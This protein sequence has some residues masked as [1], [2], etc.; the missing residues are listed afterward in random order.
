VRPPTD[1]TAL[2]VLVVAHYASERLGGEGAIPLQYYRRLRA[3]GVDVRLLTHESS[4]DE[5]LDLLPDDRERLTFAPSLPGFGPVFTRGE[6][7]PGGFRNLAW[8]VTQL[9]RQIPLRRAARELVAVHGID[10]V[11]QPIGISPVVP[12]ALYDLGAPVVQGPLQGGIDLPPAFRGRDSVPS[13]VV[14]RARPYVTRL[15]NTALPGRRKAAVVVVANERTRRSLPPGI[16]GRIE[17]MWENGVVLER[18]PAPDRGPAEAATAEAPLRLVFLGRLVA[19]KGPDV[20]LDAFAV[21]RHRLGAH[22]VLDVVGDGPERARLEEQARALGVDDVVTFVGWLDPAAGARRLARSD[23]FVFPSLEEPGGTVV[24]EAMASSLPVV[25][26]D[27]GGP[28]DLLDDTTGI[29]VAVESRETLVEGV[30]DAI[31]RL[32]ADP[33]LRT[34]LGAAGRVAVETDYDWDVLID[35]TLGFYADAV[36]RRSPD[37]VGAAR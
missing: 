24:L 25:A 3:R 26:A 23:A 12:S 18:W 37:T 10:V 34:R 15:A 33:A 22:A 9:E 8:G 30:A 35:R 20:L 32:S 28:A 7:L 6:R 2:R 29:L 14:K 21:A 13:R 16:S 27:W 4:R 5:V 11:H 36:S 19:Y 1:P 17:T 31:A